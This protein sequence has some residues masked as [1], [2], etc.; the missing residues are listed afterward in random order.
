MLYSYIHIM[1][2]YGYIDTGTQTQS[3]CVD[4]NSYVSEY[5]DTYMCVRIHTLFLHLYVYLNI[6]ITP[7]S[8]A[9]K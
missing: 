1:P 2:V 9:G 7:V 4:D 8:L 3:M 5:R 6:H